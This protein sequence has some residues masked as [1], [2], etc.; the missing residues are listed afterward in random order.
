M[1]REVK[2]SKNENMTG[3]RRVQRVAFPSLQRLSIHG[4]RDEV[5]PKKKELPSQLVRF[6]TSIGIVRAGCQK[7]QTQTQTQ[8]QRTPNG[9]RHCFKK[10]PKAPAPE[11]HVHIRVCAAAHKPFTFD[12]SVDI[13]A[14]GAKI[15]LH[16]RKECDYSASAGM[17]R[18]EFVRCIVVQFLFLELRLV[19]REPEMREVNWQHAQR[20]G[21]DCQGRMTRLLDTVNAEGV[22]C[23]ADECWCGVHDQEPSCDENRSRNGDGTKGPLTA[24]ASEETWKPSSGQ[25]DESTVLPGADKSLTERPRREVAR[26]YQCAAE[27]RVTLAFQPPGD[28]NTRALEP[29]AM[30]STFETSRIRTLE[31]TK[32][33]EKE[34]KVMV[35]TISGV[36]WPRG[37]GETP[38]WQIQQN[39]RPSPP[40]LA[41]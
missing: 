28:K 41:R 32:K 30:R 19:N 3:D 24:S 9:C 18:D 36:V 8:T 31:T 38:P 10:K 17:P 13:E 27:I 6:L 29:L 40:L 35:R 12:E 22:R 7:T 11:S 39:T 37:A 2:C 14:G 4:R 16:D 34:L 26:S 23:R 21:R 1:R 15:P 5:R 33:K 25:D 20:S